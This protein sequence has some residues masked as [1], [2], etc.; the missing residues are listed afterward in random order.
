MD[1][2]FYLTFERPWFFLLLLILPVIWLL[3]F[4]S[5]A[6]LGRWRRLFAISFRSL[7]LLLLIAALAGTQ[8]QRKTDKL[9]VLYLLDQS[10]SIPASKRENML[11][12]VVEEVR[13]NRR[14][15][16]ADMAGIIVFGA[17]AKI[18]VPPFDG[19]LPVTDRIESLIDL[20]VGATNIE[21]ALKLAK[22]SFP[23]DTARRVVLV[24]DGNENLG[25]ALKLA[26]AM[27]SDGVGIDVIAI[28]IDAAAEVSIEKMVTP[29]DVRKGQEFETRIILNNDHQPSAD[30]PTGNVAGKLRVTRRTAQTEELVFEQEIE[31]E[32]GKNIRSFVSKLDRSATYSLNASFVPFDRKQD[33]IEQ[34]NFASAFVH[35]RG[36]GKVLLI[37][38]GF[39]QGEFL[40]L[41]TALQ[42]N[43]IEIDIMTTENLFSSTSELLSYD[44]V[45]LANLARATTSDGSG[46]IQSFTD[47]QIKMLVDNCE[48]LGCGIV[49]IGGDRSF[50]AGGW[51]NSLLEKAMPVDFQIKN[52]KVSAVGALALLMHACEMPRGNFW[53]QK[54]AESAI[55]LLGPMDYCG[56]ML[57]SHQRGRGEWLWKLP[58]GIDRVFNNRQTMLG[59][60]K[61]M[62]P[63]DMPDF[64]QP[65][66]QMLT[67]LNGVNASAKHAIIISDG[68]PSPPN[69]RTLNAFVENNIKISTVAIG[70]HG[71]PGSTPLKR[72][73][74]TTGG[75]YYVIRDPQALPQIYQREA[76]RVAKPVVKESATGMQVVP[77]AGTGNHEI[78]RG[79]QLESLGLFN[80]YVMTT[81]KQ[82]SLVEQLLLSNDPPDD[83]GENSTL[84][85]SW[86]YG[87]GRTVVFTSDGGYRWLRNSE[88]YANLFVQMVRHSMRPITENANFNVASEVK[89]GK[90]RIVVTALNEDEEF[91][92]FLDIKGRGVSPQAGDIELNFSQ[93]GP[94]RYIA[95]H[96]IEG[97]G[98]FLYSLFPGDGYERLMTGISVPYSTE[99]TDRSTNLALL[100]TLVSFQPKGGQPGILM[101]GDLSRSGIDQLL[102]YNTFRPTLT[103]AAGFRD[104]WNLLLL[105]TAIVFLQDIFVRRVAVSFAWIGTGINSIKNRL[106]GKESTQ[107]PASISRLQSRKA[108]IE[109]EIES[110]R[111]AMRFQPEDDSPASG[112]AKLEQVLASEIEKTP[113][114]PPKI[115]KEKLA[116]EQENTFTSRLLEAKRKAQQ[117][118]PKDKSDP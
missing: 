113:A 1:F 7:V 85:A 63:G 31:L 27:A 54:I 83:G 82:S 94:G 26:Q 18:E 41:I 40:E 30:N 12:Y 96:D 108:E 20:N 59:L 4:T 17:E 100:R 78:L 2:G 102:Q 73:A 86:R 117:N 67:G 57:W 98:N 101:E 49:M 104:V 60:V 23:E 3:S 84:L 97:T 35:V 52:D 39:H 75:S 74:D 93:V 42:S 14:E 43:S 103:A 112:K 89:D 64:E 111:A 110:R 48:H 56:I 10:E 25:D 5:L 62:V 81:V 90:A 69:Q 66:R 50:G 33:T 53:E 95:E 87:N 115:P 38:D 105:F 16:T 51:T 106:T 36:Q 32:P 11:R 44:S 107:A 58:S 61:R 72:I 88:D 80:G 76:R 71:P 28:D 79:I 37:E 34:N 116:A 68:D 19:D 45:I 13:Q 92:N 77:V 118:Q 114:L 70:T 8:W 9:T 99:F 109:R 21:A 65:M 29:S 91:L 24:S 47:A 22:A 55:E 15:K 6:G 46:D